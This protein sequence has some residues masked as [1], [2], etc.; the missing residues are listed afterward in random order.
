MG[1]ENSFLPSAE[2]LR[3]NFRVFIPRSSS[4][5]ALSSFLAREILRGQ[6]AVLLSADNRFRPDVLI[7]KARDAGRT[8]E[9]LLSRLLFS[10]AFTIHQLQET[11]SDR[12]EPALRQSGATL[13]VVTGVLP[14]FADEAVEARE[15]FRV[16]DVLLKSLQS[17]SRA[18]RKILMPVVLPL[19]PSRRARTLFARLHSPRYPEGKT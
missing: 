4:P 16:L 15:A 12:L 6:T 3:S 14:L 9:S 5:D 8:P 2:R 10:R 19:P 17:L 18:D 7:Q 13:V 1:K 11:I